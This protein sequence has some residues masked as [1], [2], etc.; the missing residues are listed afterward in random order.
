MSYLLLTFGSR[1]YYCFCIGKC[2]PCHWRLIISKIEHWRL[3]MSKGT[4]LGIAWNNF[5]SL[6]GSLSQLSHL[7]TLVLDGCK[8]LEVLPKL[9]PSV[10][11]I[12]ACD[13]TFGSY[14]DPFRSR[15]NVF[16]SCPKLFKNVTVDSEGSS[17]SKTQCLDSSITSQGSN[18]HLSAFLG[19]LG[20]ETKNN[21]DV[22]VKECGV[23]LICEEDIEQG[24]ESKYHAFPGK[25]EACLKLLDVDS[26]ELLPCK[27]AFFVFSV[28]L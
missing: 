9:P 28:V 16:S 20:S 11:N 12:Y 6:P 18:N 26:P 3:I 22:E 15:V 23:R 2:Q 21:E 19:H 8:K 5:T 14:K 1:I 10:W 27:S 25:V 17:I 24:A 7:I 4:T 13:C